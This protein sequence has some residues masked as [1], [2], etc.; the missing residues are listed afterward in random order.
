M[1]LKTYAKINLDLNIL[2]RQDN[3]YHT[4]RSTFQ[5][6]TLY[7]LLEVEPAAH[8]S[9]TGRVYRNNLIE[10]AKDALEKAT[11]KEMCCSIHLTKGIPECAGL[12]GG[13]SDAAAAL[14]AMN[15]ICSLGMGVK[16]L[17]DIAFEIGSD[18][19]FFLSNYGSAVVEQ[20]GELLSYR[21]LD[22]SPYFVLAKPPFMKSTK[23]MFERHDRTGKNFYD[24]MCQLCPD[25]QRLK[26]H[27]SKGAHECGMTGSGP[28]IFAGFPTLEESIAAVK[29]CTVDG[30]FFIARP[31]DISH[32]VIG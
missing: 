23:D 22:V 2:D 1:M 16:A 31:V 19:P 12:G 32:E 28:T 6:I 29:L 14:W 3:G 24:I 8:F 20:T 4:I 7:D 15:T 10:K 11:G 17:Q 21:E 13:S 18:V 25:V 27:F 26:E 30:K 9:L 5:S